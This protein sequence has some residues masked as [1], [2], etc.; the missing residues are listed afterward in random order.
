[1]RRSVYL[2][3]PIHGDRNPNGWRLNIES[4]L[5]SGWASVNPLA[6]EPGGAAPSDIIKMDYNLIRKC[7]AI[8]AFA[9]RPSW[10]TAMEL[11][12]AQLM[13]VPV[14]GIASQWKDQ[15][16]WLIFHTTYKVKTIQEAINC[17]KRNW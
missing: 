10:G 7:D 6:C 16:P 8:I 14:I 13:A 4:K 12:Y 17:L 11:A 15:S 5:P 1:M 9:E 2:A 3:G